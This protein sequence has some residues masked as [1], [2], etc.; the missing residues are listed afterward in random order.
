M[1]IEENAQY[2]IPTADT[3]KTLRKK[4]S[5]TQERKQTS[6][7]LANNGHR[8]PASLDRSATPSHKSEVWKKYHRFLEADQAGPGIIAHDHTVDH[9]IVVIKEIKHRASESQRRQL[10]KVMDEKPT[11]LV[12]LTDYA[13]N[14]F[15]V[16][17]VYE[18][19]EISMHHIQATSRRDVT[20][21][22]L[23]IIGKEVG[24]IIIYTGYRLINFF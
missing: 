16:H 12:R 24:D 2:P 17:A 15:T 18:P 13:L 22:D 19:L 21:I 3:P 20:E 8:F 9:N 10:H 7:N 1:S 23:A 5:R 14:T 4:S 11:N 6:E